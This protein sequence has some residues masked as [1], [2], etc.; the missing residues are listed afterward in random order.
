MNKWILSLLAFGFMSTAYAED[1]QPLIKYQERTEIDFESVDV[2]G[3][4]VKPEGIL[5]TER[6]TAIFNP[7]IKLRYDFNSEMSQSVND[8][9]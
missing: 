7:L 5:T 9:K 8:I 3:E 2:N 4:M 6:T 1:S